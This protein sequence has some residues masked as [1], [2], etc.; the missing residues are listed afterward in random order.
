MGKLGWMTLY[1]ELGDR[2][3]EDDVNEEGGRGS[4]DDAVEDGKEEGR[5]GSY[6]SKS[7]SRVA[8]QPE[9]GWP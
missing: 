8:S 4:K 2:Y 6:G 1:R 9:A 5:T 3:G 7:P